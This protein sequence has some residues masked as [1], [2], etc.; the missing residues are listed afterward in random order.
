MAENKQT[1]LS[2]AE[3]KSNSDYLMEL[4]KRVEKATSS[5]QQMSAQHGNGTEPQNPPQD[6]KSN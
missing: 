5:Q 4:S 6:L 1:T 2:P 3:W